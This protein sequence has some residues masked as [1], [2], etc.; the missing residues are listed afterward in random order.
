M[1]GVLGQSLHLAG[2]LSRVG[3]DG[4][5]PQVE[6]L[7]EAGE[8]QAFGAGCG[9]RLRFPAGAGGEPLRF[10]D[11]LPRAGIQGRLPEV[12]AV[13]LGGGKQNPIAGE[14]VAGGGEFGQAEA[15]E[16]GERPGLDGWAAFERS[17]PP[18]ARLRKRAAAGGGAKQQPLAVRRP[19]R[20]TSG[21]HLGE[22]LPRR[23]PDGRRHVDLSS[24]RSHQPAAPVPHRVGDPLAVG[25][26]PRPPALCG[27]QPLVA[28]A[29]SRD[30]IDPAP[31][32]LGAE[33]DGA[34]VGG[35][36]RV[37]IV[38][39]MVR[40]PHGLAAGHLLHPDVQIPFAA[41]VGGV[42]HQLAVC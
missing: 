7:G 40:D 30:H 33:G 36:R 4:Q 38:G 27:N 14:P 6:I 41:A 34:R 23:A 11:D 8:H 31:F 9:R 5:A 17:H 2:D 28:A 39:G 3:V 25:G 32:P 10:A 19:D 13:S 18:V 29:Q 26:K 16:D 42:G 15:R 1:G 24:T 37:A 35:K 20:V 12:G 21:S 22:K